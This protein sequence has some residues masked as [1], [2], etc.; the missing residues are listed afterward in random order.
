MKI[1]GGLAPSVLW[2]RTKTG[3]ALTEASI[4]I[5]PVPGLAESGV[6]V[7]PF[8]ENQSEQGHGS[9]LPERVTSTTEPCLP[10]G[11]KIDSSAGA[12]AEAGIAANMRAE[13]M[14]NPR[15][16]VDQAKSSLMRRP[17]LTSCTGRLFVSC[18]IVAG[19]MP[20]FV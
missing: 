18:R 4:L 14:A 10:P 1:I 12:A 6:K 8:S 19:S 16:P 9:I 3:P 5:L 20:I 15:I 2:A 7:S 17:L 13:T 11:G